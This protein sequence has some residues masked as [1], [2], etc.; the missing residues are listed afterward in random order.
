[1]SMQ[2]DGSFTYTTEPGY[3]GPDAFTYEAFDGVAATQA[4]V[5]ITVTP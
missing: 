5:N 3:N 2:S 1:V 4:T